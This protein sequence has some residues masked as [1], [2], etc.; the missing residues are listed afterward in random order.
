[1]IYVLI[2]API[3]YFVSAPVSFTNS[4]IMIIKY[5]IIDPHISSQKIVKFVFGY[6]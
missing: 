6:Q 2:N 1:M 4:Q 5:V 3:C